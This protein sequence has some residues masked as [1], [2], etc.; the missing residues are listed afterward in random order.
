MELFNTARGACD[1]PAYGRPLARPATNLVRP[2]L[3]LITDVC[4]IGEAAPGT[5]N[6]GAM[7]IQENQAAAASAPADTKRAFI[8]FPV[9]IDHPRIV[10]L[11]ASSLPDQRGYLGIG[12]TNAGGSSYI[13]Y[14]AHVRTQGITSWGVRTTADLTWS[15][16]GDLTLDGVGPG[17]THTLSVTGYEPSGFMHFMA[18]RMLPSA[19]PVVGMRIDVSGSG[20]PAGLDYWTASGDLSPDDLYLAYG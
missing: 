1:L 7:Q 5:P 9:P 17:K 20:S 10:L 2:G 6:Q 3:T 15:N 18:F 12:A 19:L 11:W 16:Q 4:W 13:D 8:R 14:T